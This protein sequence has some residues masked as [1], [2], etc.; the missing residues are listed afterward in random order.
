M[1]DKS[2]SILYPII[3]PRSN[4]ENT[5]CMQNCSIN[6]VYQISHIADEMVSLLGEKWMIC[7][8]STHTTQ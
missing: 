2:S 7:G 4:Q 5:G 6:L 3:H 1:N 8:S